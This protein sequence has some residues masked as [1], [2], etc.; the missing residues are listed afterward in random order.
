[1]PDL[2]PS[3]DAA[4]PPS[5]AEP[6]SPRPT[7]GQL[8]PHLV[9]VPDLAHL[10]GVEVPTARK[11]TATRADLAHR[12]LDASEFW[13][14]IPAFREISAEQFRD[15]Q[16][17]TSHSVTSVEQLASVL[18]ELVPPEFLDDVR[19]GMRRAPM[20]VRLSPYVVGLIDWSRPYTDPLR[21]Q[22]LPLGSRL[23]AD[24]P[25][26][27]LDSLHERDD[28]P[29]PGLVHRYPDKALFLAIGVCPVYCRF[30]TRSY[31][32]GG[33]TETVAKVP[34]SP[35][36]ARWN[37]AFAYLLSRPEIED[38]V[39][40]GGDSYFLS[41]N[42]L[43]KIG[44]TLL[45]IPHLRRL[46]FASKGPAV[47]PMK[48]LTH[49][50]W[51][52]ALTTVSDRGRALGKEVALHTHFNHPR[53][54]TA[55]TGE[56]MTRLFQRGVKVRNQSVLIRGVNDNARTLTTLVRRLSY[57]NVQPYYVYQHDMVSGVEDLRTRVKTAVELERQVRG[58]TA[59]FN[60]PTFVNDVPGGG[61]KRDV[62]SYEH[63][64]E[65]TGISVYRSPA[66]KGDAVYLYFDPLHLLPRDGRRRWA[67]PSE[68][69]AMVTEALV[70]AGVPAPLT[71][72]C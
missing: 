71:C 58:A 47:M 23:R 67:R 9:D 25:R 17:Q 52:D 54:I 65:V 8:Y 48:I 37:R 30:C 27:A 10:A 36:H 29:T 59:G 2:T 33:D 24:H 70:A 38:V 7:V 14:C 40:S 46:R 60:T 41:S 3:D 32:I 26:L 53:E 64:D 19:A 68:H 45:A 66:V 6:P 1:M 61:G 15:H 11:R 12:D 13:R 21:L 62:H 28:S 72:A 49:D 22:F 35:D 39:V 20:N 56:A 4:K 44:E 16:F 31:A 57:V 5:P 63:Y 50:A 43:R 42:N 55:I 18:G 69:E 51:V 34:Y